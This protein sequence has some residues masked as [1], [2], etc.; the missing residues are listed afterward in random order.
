MPHLGVEAACTRRML[1]TL[2]IYRGNV[3]S[4]PIKHTL[5]PVTSN[6][7]LPD[8][9][10][11][12][13]WLCFIAFDSPTPRIGISTLNKTPV[14]LVIWVCFAPIQNEDLETVA[15][16]TCKLYILYELLVCSRAVSL[17]RV[18]RLPSR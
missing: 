7:S 4:W 17:C 11:I 12:T 6:K 9:L 16:L 3:S 2:D 15:G 10:P 5:K 13:C 14:L 8:Y 1:R 18:R